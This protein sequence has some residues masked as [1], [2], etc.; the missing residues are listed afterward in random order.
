MTVRTGLKHAMES[1]LIGAGV[2]GVSRARVRRR[3]LILAYHNVV[4]D[5]A[6]PAG[7]L[8]LHITRRCF[9]R[10]LDELYRHAEIVPLERIFAPAD[11]EGPRVAITFDDAYRGAV[12]EG[13]DELARRGLP[14]TVFV[15]PGLLDG[16]AFWWD[17]LAE[18][19]GGLGEDVR[20]HALERLQG[21]DAVIRS[22]AEGAGHPLRE[23][24]SHARSASA[25]E[26]A[27]ALAR[28]PFTVGS[29][30]WSHASLPRL[31]PGEVATELGPPR[32]WLSARFGPAF[33]PW[34]SYPYGHFSPMVVEAAAAA[35]Y[36]GALGIEGGWV[37]EPVPAPY[38]IPRLNVPAGLSTRG[39]ALRVA[40]LFCR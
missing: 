36:R 5:D 7:D 16:H 14:A 38:A 31:S 4:P 32:D 34:L 26:L 35:G 8:S 19:G 39:F 23:P 24:P 37:P 17:L 15:S 3:A 9:A 29:H 33:V 18:P 10:Q 2:A 30:T 21:K 11:G 12:T 22:W 27:A 28:G 25:E 20:R 13:L 1:L 6:P 40:G